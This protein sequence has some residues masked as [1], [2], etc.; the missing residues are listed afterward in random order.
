LF[1]GQNIDSENKRVYFEHHAMF[2]CLLCSLSPQMTVRLR[3]SDHADSPSQSSKIHTSA[4][5]PVIGLCV[6]DLYSLEIGGAVEAAHCEQLP[7]HNGKTYARTSGRSTLAYL[8]T[9]T[10]ATCLK[11]EM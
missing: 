1:P 6:K 7:V 5:F 9:Y 10:I 4:E 2:Q 11:L 8:Q 3:H